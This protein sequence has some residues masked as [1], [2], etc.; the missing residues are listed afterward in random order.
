MIF[1][2]CHSLHKN[3]YRFQELFSLLHSFYVIFEH[4][5]KTI[6][7]NILPRESY[8]KSIGDH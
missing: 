7:F 1:I 5:G 3:K 2:K 8:K 6:N 4:Y